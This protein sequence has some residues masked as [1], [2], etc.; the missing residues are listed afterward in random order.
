MSQRHITSRCNIQGS[1]LTVE[2]SVFVKTAISEEFIFFEIPPSKYV[3]GEN[4]ISKYLRLKA[5]YTSCFYLFNYTL[6]ETH[7]VISVYLTKFKKASR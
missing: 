6:S 4:N 5:K 7:S 1:L 3:S 2:A